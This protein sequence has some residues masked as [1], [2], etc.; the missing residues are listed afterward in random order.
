MV[1]VV[2][3]FSYRSHSTRTRKSAPLPARSPRFRVM[4]RRNNRPETVWSHCRRKLHP[5]ILPTR[6]KAANLPSLSQSAIARRR[7][8]HQ[9]HPLPLDNMPPS[10]LDRARS[11]AP[12]LKFRCIRERLAPFRLPVLRAPGLPHFI[13][14]T[15]RLST[16]NIRKPRPPFLLVRLTNFTSCTKTTPWTRRGLFPP[17]PSSVPPNEAIR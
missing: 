1:V 13:P 7:Q 9:K 4:V 16:R 11:G 5:P 17:R 15:V 10:P 8:V 2:E 12:S 14:G 3:N 6:R